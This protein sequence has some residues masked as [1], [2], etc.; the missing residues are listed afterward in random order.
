MHVNLSITF[1]EV[2]VLA[3]LFFSIFLF[4][5]SISVLLSKYICV[6]LE[7]ILL[8]VIIKK[9]LGFYRIVLLYP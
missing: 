9:D 4:S 8:F 5:P 7:H 1:K 3:C 6:V 2:S